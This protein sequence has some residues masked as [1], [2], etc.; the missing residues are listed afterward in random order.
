MREIGASRRPDSKIIKVIYEI[1]FSDEYSGVE[2][3][4]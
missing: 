4:G 2:C 1:R 3:G